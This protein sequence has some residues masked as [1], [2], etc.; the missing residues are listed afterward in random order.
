MSSRK[1]FEE[2]RGQILLKDGRQVLYRRACCDDEE[3]LNRMFT[4][5]TEESLYMRYVGYHRPTREE[6]RAILEKEETQEIS[7]VAT[8]VENDGEIVAQIRCIFLNPPTSAE[9]GIVVRDDWQNQGLGTA[10]VEAILACASQAGVERIVGIIGLSNDRMIHVCNKLGFA[11]CS[12]CYDT[13]KMSVSLSNR[14]L[15]TR[16]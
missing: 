11:T 15:K 6:I 13:V 2:V 14:V 10:L 16:P 12:S 7:L 3:A 9:V 1:T 8:P 4:R 5:L